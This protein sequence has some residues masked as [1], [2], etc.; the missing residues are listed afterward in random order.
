MANSPEMTE[1]MVDI[2]LHDAHTDAFMQLIPRQRAVV[3][4]LMYEGKIVQY[5][6]SLDR[7]KLWMIVI[8]R[9]E[10]QVLEYLSSFPLIH[11]MDCEI[12]PLLFTNSAQQTFSHISL[13]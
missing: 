9:D 5:A 4:S 3:N 11:F 13:N 8:A 6:V 12:A 1:F 7:S 10:E 2:N